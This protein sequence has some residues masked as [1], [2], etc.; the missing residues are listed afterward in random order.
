[1][2]IETTFGQRLKF[3]RIRLGFTQE[4]M[5]SVSGLSKQAQIN[6]EQGKRYPDSNY[7]QKISCAGVD[8]Q[9][10][11]SAKHTVLE[12]SSLTG[13]EVELLLAY[14]NSCEKAKTLMMFVA[15]CE[16]S[17]REM[18]NQLNSLKGE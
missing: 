2:S 15:K 14:R 13:D 7:L 11:I 16:N 9:Y 17:K 3:E 8:I 1:M 6:Y 10:L 12:S 18:E 4:E 5:A